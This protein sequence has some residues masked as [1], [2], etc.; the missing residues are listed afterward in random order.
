MVIRLRD[1]ARRTTSIQNWKS[2]D[3]RDVAGSVRL[4]SFRR[5]VDVELDSLAT[6]QRHQ[7]GAFKLLDVDEYIVGARLLK[8][9][10]APCTTRMRGSPFGP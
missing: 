4:P 8:S 10:L 9:R 1:R 3:D 2:V 5:L 6:Y 7:A